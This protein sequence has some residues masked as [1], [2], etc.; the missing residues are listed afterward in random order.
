MIWYALLKYLYNFKYS[1][2]SA[3]I[4]IGTIIYIKHLNDRFYGLVTYMFFGGFIVYTVYLNPMI[5]HF[6]LIS[7]CRMDWR[8]NT[9]LIRPIYLLGNKLW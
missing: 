4:V 2:L 1:I 6:S 7:T 3:D 8:E 9:I 5:R